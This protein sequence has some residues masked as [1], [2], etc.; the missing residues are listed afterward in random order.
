M[1]D[2]CVTPFVEPW[3]PA[4]SIPGGD[5]LCPAFVPTFSFSFWRARKREATC[6]YACVVVPQDEM[7]SSSD[8]SF[9][10]YLRMTPATFDYLLGE[11]ARFARKKRSYRSLIRHSIS[12]KECLIITLRFLATGVS[13]R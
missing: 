5:E 13:H 6:K 12:L 8:H 1:L 9:F 7:R 10:R 2:S 11:E 4:A 3:R